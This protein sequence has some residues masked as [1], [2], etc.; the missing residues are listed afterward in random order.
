MQHHFFDPSIL[1]EY[2][3]RGLVGTTLSDDDAFAIGRSF[4]AIL[5]RRGGRRVA[6]GRDGRMS[7]PSLEAAL[8]DGLVR[9]G[10]DVVR[11]GIGPT[12]M[13]YF[14]EAE[15]GVD[16]GIQVTGSHNPSDYN[17]F[18]MVIGRD[19]FFGDEIKGL[20][21]IAAEGDWPEGN[22]SVEEV[23]AID[24]YVERL[25]RDFD[26][27]GYRIGWDAGNGAAG[28]ALEKLVARLP[29]EHH[30]LFTELDGRFPNISPT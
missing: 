14:A 30:T 23:S 22:G 18:K 28:P 2:D 5:S 25:M 9:S 29:G 17:G 19:S 6:V 13:L 26:G 24:L 8:V 10:I 20:G 12:P 21:H 7:S 27:Q 3:I 16:G 1:R 15:L 11:I 4:G